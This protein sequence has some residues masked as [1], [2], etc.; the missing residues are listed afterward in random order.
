[1]IGTAAVFFLLSYSLTQSF[2]YFYYLNEY[3]STT[4]YNLKGLR[5]KAV[6]ITP[7]LSNVRGV[8]VTESKCFCAN[9]ILNHSKKPSWTFLEFNGFLVEFFN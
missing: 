8:C 7:E 6:L 1:M 5:E 9:H 2:Q 3:E 4:N